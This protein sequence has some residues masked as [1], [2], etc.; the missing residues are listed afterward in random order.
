MFVLFERSKKNIIVSRGSEGHCYKGGSSF[1][2]DGA[3]VPAPGSLLSC[4]RPTNLTGCLLH[5][6]AA[7]SLLSVF[8]SR[9]L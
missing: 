2:D 8:N 9:V 5:V 3:H 6:C 4:L 1:R 7:N